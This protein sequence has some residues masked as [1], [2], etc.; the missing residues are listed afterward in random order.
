MTYRIKNGR[1]D[2]LLEYQ[3]ERTKYH[4]AWGHNKQEKSL[5][6][7]VSSEIHLDLFKYSISVLCH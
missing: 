1:K 3:R 5:G 4:A 6:P 2:F 7:H